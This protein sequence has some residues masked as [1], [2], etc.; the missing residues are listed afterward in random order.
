LPASSSNRTL[1]GRLRFPGLDVDSFISP[2]DRAALAN[3]Q[4]LPL[5]SPLVKKFNELAID[6]VLY[7]Q[8]S[9]ESVRCGPRQFP[10]L[11]RLLQEAC[12]ILEAPEPELYLQYDGTY[13]SYTAGVNR[14]FIIL[15][16]ALLEDFTDD[17]L[18][19][20]LGHELGH[21]K[22]AHVLY[23]MLGRF[24]MPLLDALGQATLG[25]GQLAGIGLV[26]AF[27]EWMRQAEFTCDRAG[28]LVCQDQQIA[29]TTIMKLG[30]GVSR[31]S[32]EMSVQTFLEQARAHAAHTPPEGLAKALLFV[33]YNWQLDHPQVVFRAKELDA[34]I[35]TGAYE[36]I[37]RGDY[38]KDEY[39]EARREVAEW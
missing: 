23:G 3:L 39:A 9:A 21:V 6:R 13:N 17:E 28:L 36:K 29:F 37:L 24:L 18:L 10:T 7:V 16:S 22:C 5:L 26:S 2:R 34:W 27:N 30:C 19:F 15:H 8:N 4:K 31:L 1:H 32:G 38:G 33:L 35:T 25:V 12:D 14:T 20:I 11:H